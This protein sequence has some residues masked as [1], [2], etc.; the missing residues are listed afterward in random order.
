MDKNRVWIYCRTA[1]K[2]ETAIEMQKR[3]LRT[4]AAEQ[5][6]SIVGGSSDQQNGLTLERPGL[7]EVNKAVNDMRIDIL[8]VANVSRIA[9][10]TEH[11][12]QYYGFLDRHKVKICTP[13]RNEVDM[14][15]EFKDL[16]ALIFSLKETPK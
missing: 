9:R 11:I 1:Q 14:I 4:Y 16:Y 5:G 8:L 13:N 3:W 2:N 15:P 10:S 7:L 6:F 12:V